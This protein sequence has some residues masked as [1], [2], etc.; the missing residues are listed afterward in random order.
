MGLCAG[1]KLVAL[2]LFMVDWWLV[3]KRSD[4]EAV[5]PVMAIGD[6]VTSGSIISL[7]KRKPI[8]FQYL[9]CNP[10]NMWI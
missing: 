7:D 4:A 9:I 10:E 1:I 2:S 8:S 5:Q 3:R 6:I